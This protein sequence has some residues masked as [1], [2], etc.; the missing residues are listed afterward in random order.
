MNMYT[1]MYVYRDRHTDVCVCVRIHSKRKGSKL[2]LKTDV[3]P[4]REL[5]KEKN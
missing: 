5:S 2:D 4:F 1:G 3:S